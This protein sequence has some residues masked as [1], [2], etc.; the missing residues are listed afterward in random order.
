MGCRVWGVGNSGENGCEAELRNWHDLTGQSQEDEV[1]SRNPLGWTLV[2]AP[3]NSQL[4][5]EDR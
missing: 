1:I 3:G 5:P 4:L 2:S